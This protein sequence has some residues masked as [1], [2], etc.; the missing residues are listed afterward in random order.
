MKL[1]CQ[2][3]IKYELIKQACADSGN[4]Y[5]RYGH[6]HGSAMRVT[7]HQPDEKALQFFLA[8]DGVESSRVDLAIDFV[9]ADEHD[10]QQAEEWFFDFHY[11][12][13]RRPGHSLRIVI[14]PDTGNR[15]R[16]TGQG[17]QHG[18]VVA[19]YI[20]PRGCCRLNQEPD[21]FHIEYRLFGI[22]SLRRHGLYSLRKVVECD[23][24]EFLRAHLLFRAF[25]PEKLGRAISNHRHEVVRTRARIWK[26]PR[27]ALTYNVDQ[28]AGAIIAS[29]YQVMELLDAEVFFPI[30]KQLRNSLITMPSIIPPR[31]IRPHSSKIE[32]HTAE[33]RAFQNPKLAMPKPLPM[34]LPSLPQQPPRHE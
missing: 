5:P 32:L 22:Q 33:I 13:F 34:P 24:E 19:S 6:S 10:L 28:R 8:M 26:H 23:V 15:T 12:K 31:M 9:F 21:C 14:N 16:Y 27:D 3:P 18:V 11:M 29:N 7:L 30:R 17:G 4:V 25:I 20:D 1:R 2:R